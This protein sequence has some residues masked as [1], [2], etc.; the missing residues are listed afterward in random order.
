[1]KVIDIQQWDRKVPFE[2]FIKYTNPI[3]SLSTRLDVTQLY[4]YCRK[5]KTSFFA[6]FLFAAV[7]VLNEI[8]EFR[9]RIADDKVVL[10]DSI[11]PNYIVLTNKNVIQTCRSKMTSDYKKFYDGVR[12]D[13]EAAKNGQSVGKTFNAAKEND[14]Y[15]ISCLSWV[16]LQSMSNP[17]DLKDKESS[18][19]PRLTWGKFVDENG[20][21][22]MFMDI[23]AH[24]AL[25]DGEPVCR[26]FVNLQ[27]EL[28]DID[29]FLKTHS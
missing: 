27:K 18:S 2:N 4:D 24:H 5:T 9:L 15:Y 28:D 10:Y 8:E 12:R 19:I 26:A 23:A 22:K 16:D 20:R 3:F 14:C 11:D 1:M 29:M 17:Y 7:S 21:K 25:M 6:N 13:I